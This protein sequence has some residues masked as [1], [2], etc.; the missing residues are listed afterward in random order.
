MED[1]EIDNSRYCAECNVPLGFSNTL[2]SFV[3]GNSNCPVTVV[4]NTDA[5][6]TNLSQGMRPNVMTVDESGPGFVSFNPDLG[7]IKRNK[8]KFTVSGNLRN[9]KIKV[10]GYPSRIGFYDLR[11]EEAEEKYE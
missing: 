7:D 5:Q 9:Q 4:P 6:L 10:D 11:D 8:V 3:C 1:E 2:N